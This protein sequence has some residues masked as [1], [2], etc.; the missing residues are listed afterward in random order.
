[1]APAPRMAVRVRGVGAA[2]LV[3][4]QQEIRPHG[5]GCEGVV[6][7]RPRG[8]P[9]SAWFHKRVSRR[10]NWTRWM[11]SIY[12]FDPKLTEMLR[13]ALEERVL[14]GTPLSATEI[15]IQWKGSL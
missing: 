8:Y 9:R 14:M 4:V 1:M 6:I 5:A 3:G 11:R 7:K 2:R 10:K 13:C 15:Y 12:N